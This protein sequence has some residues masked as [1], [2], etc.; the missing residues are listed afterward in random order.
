MR[1]SATVEGE[2]EEEEEEVV[3][4]DT[5]E[6]VVEEEEEEEEDESTTP[7]PLCWPPAP[8]LLFP[9]PFVFPCGALRESRRPTATRPLAATLLVL[10]PRGLARAPSCRVFLFVAVLVLMLGAGDDRGV[11]VGVE[12]PDASPGLV[13]GP[14]PRPTDSRPP[15]TSVPEASLW[16]LTECVV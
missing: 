10:R 9:L 3:E 6:E 4:E 16:L 13:R 2:E 5:L 15:E 12:R 11:A 8:L 14:A 1:R 7:V